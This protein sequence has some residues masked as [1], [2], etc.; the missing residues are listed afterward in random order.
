MVFHD[1]PSKPGRTP[2]TELSWVYCPTAKK[3]GNEQ[4]DSQEDDRRNYLEAGE[5]VRQI[6]C[7]QGVAVIRP[8]ISVSF[9]YHSYNKIPST[10]WAKTTDVA[11]LEK[12]APNQYH[13]TESQGVGREIAIGGFSGGESVFL[14]LSAPT[15]RRCLHPITCGLLLCLQTRNKLL[16]CSFNNCL[17]GTIGPTWITQGQ[18]STSKS[19]T[20]FMWTVFLLS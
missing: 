4:W 14:P 17:T 2:R 9:S 15:S 13:W 19:S 16:S 10:R 3:G 8:W 7:R 20:S 1:L 6:R 18:P 12:K 5:E 11:V